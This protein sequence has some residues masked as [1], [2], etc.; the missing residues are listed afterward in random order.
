M[1]KMLAVAAAGVAI[2][3]GGMPAAPVVRAQEE[4]VQYE[5]RTKEGVLYFTWDSKEFAKITE[6]DWKKIIG[7]PLYCK[8]VKE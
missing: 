5:C 2:A 6:K 4:V 8:A 7:I 1:R 3:T